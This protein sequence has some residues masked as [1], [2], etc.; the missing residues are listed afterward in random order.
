MNERDAAPQDLVAGNVYD[1][2]HTRNP[3]ARFLM[4]SFDRDMAELLR[5]AGN[6]DSVL[7]VGCGEGEVLRK[8]A[9]LFP[10]AYLLGADVSPDVVEEAQRRH[11]DLS[12]ETRSIYETDHH[13][14][15][16]DLIVAAEVFE[17]LDDPLD[18]LRAVVRASNKFIFASVPEEP[19]WRI[20]NC[21]R[22]KYIRHWGNTPGHV[23]HWS[24]QAFIGFL[25]S[26]VDVIA[27]RKPRPWTMAL[28]ALK[29]T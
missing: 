5:I 15:K 23:Q 8:L 14:R 6:V 25:E 29:Q 17:H 19:L 21:A 10:R 11:P 9:G 12:F 2:Y 26:E 1:K 13:P 27:V 18:A 24:T 3:I 22:A 7:E 28:C 4:H 20:L 16:F